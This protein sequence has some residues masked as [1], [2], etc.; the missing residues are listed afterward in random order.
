MPAKT[1]NNFIRRLINLRD[2]RNWSKTEVARKLGLSS[3][4]RYANYEYGTNEPDLNMLKQ[5]ADLYDVTTDYLLGE[6]SASKWIAKKDTT[7]LKDFLAAH[8]D[9]MTYGGETLT[10]EERQQVR[11]AMAVIF[12]E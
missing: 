4:Q 9:S 7:D 6:D 1:Q 5:I 3:M 11:V 2:S 10:E 8:V 12:W